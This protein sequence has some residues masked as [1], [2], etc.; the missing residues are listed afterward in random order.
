MVLIDVQNVLFVFFLLQKQT[1]VI[2]CALYGQEFVP[3]KSVFDSPE[4]SL[5]RRLNFINQLA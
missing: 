5:P 4:I 1:R 2:Y 3:R